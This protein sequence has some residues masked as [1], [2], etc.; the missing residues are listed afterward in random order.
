MPI[1]FLF[2]YTN[3]LLL[4]ILKIGKHGGWESELCRLK[5]NSNELTEKTREIR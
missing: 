3:I 1:V 4:V 5:K 2:E